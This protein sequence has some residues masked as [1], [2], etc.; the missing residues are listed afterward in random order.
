MKQTISVWDSEALLA[1][2][3]QALESRSEW[4]IYNET[5]GDQMVITPDEP[6]PDL[7]TLTLWEKE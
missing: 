5:N 3:R 7:V 1:M 2:L 6:A 4:T